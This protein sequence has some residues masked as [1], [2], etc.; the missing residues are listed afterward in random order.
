MKEKLLGFYQKHRILVLYNAF[1]CLTVIV[2][3]GVFCFLN[4]FLTPDFNGGYLI[5]HVVSWAASVL[6][7]YWGNKKFV[8]KPS[9]DRIRVAQFVSF[10]MIRVFTEVMTLVLMF[11]LVSMA[12]FNSYLMK[13]LTDILLVIINYFF[14]RYISFSGIDDKIDDTRHK[15]SASIAEHREEHSH[16]QK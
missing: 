15:I 16:S 6:F 11:V 12:E 1:G 8:F 5:A 9:T 7:S 14:T 2:N 13:L 3:Y 10:V 4:L